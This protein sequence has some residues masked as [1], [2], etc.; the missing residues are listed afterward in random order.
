M[1]LKNPNYFADKSGLLTFQNGYP[2]Y[3]FQGWN[4]RTW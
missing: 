2:V 3:F 4:R 1:G